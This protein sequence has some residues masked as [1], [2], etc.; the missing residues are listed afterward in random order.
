VIRRQ[1]Q[2]SVQRLLRAERHT[3]SSRGW[4]EL[5]VEV[6]WWIEVEGEP[7]RRGACQPGAKLTADRA[8]ERSPLGS[9][10]EIPTY[11]QDIM[12][13]IVGT[14]IGAATEQ[15]CRRLSSSMPD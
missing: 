13:A 7:R 3:L 4:N 8:V 9:T 10:S 11:T 1:Q 14:V 12:D 6:G 15:L 5:G 2:E